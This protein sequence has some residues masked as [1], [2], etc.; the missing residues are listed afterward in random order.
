MN[1]SSLW[2]GSET[3]WRQDSRPLK[4]WT[5]KDISIIQCAHV[6]KKRISGQGGG[7]STVELKMDPMEWRSLEDRQD[8][9]M[10][11][12]DE[13][14]KKMEWNPW[15]GQQRMERKSRKGEKMERI[16]CPGKNWSAGRYRQGQKKGE[17]SAKS[18]VLKP[19][20][21]WREGRTYSKHPDSRRN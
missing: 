15:K 5:L 11:G 4:Q 9:K 6:K 8:E 2:L 7:A 19:G 3:S 17:N 10:L 12:S 1:W 13:D 16:S 18:P 14:S 21:D 20:K